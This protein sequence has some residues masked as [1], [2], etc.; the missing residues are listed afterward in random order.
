MS[1]DAKAFE[2]RVVVIVTAGHDTGRLGLITQADERYVWYVDG[3]YRS[4]E[5]PKIKNKRHV[6]SLG[7]AEARRYDQI[8]NQTDRGAANASIRKLLKDFSQG[9]V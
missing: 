3:K 1:H 6:R 9:E 2:P 8:M 7:H 5:Q 4:I